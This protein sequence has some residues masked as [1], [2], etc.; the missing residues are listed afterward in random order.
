M[1][2]A[3]LIPPTHPRLPLFC[4]LAVLVEKFGYGI[5]TLARKSIH[6]LHILDVFAV[7]HGVLCLLFLVQKEVKVI[8]KD[9]AIPFLLPLVL[10]TV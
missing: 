6:G 5:F 9:K 2:A 3:V 8:F 7:W 10:L 1:I 4:L